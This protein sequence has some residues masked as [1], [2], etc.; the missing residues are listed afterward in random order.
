MSDKY[1]QS[2]E[3]LHENLYIR[4]HRELERYPPPLGRRFDD[5][6]NEEEE[7]KIYQYAHFRPV[8]PWPD[9]TLELVI[10]EASKKERRKE[11]SLI[12]KVV[13]SKTERV[14]ID[15]RN[16]GNA[17]AWF[18][19]DIA[20]IWEAFLHSRLQIIPKVVLWGSKLKEREHDWEAMRLLWDFVEGWLA[21]QGVKQVYTHDRDPAF[22]ECD[23]S[24]SPCGG[25][26]CEEGRRYRQFLLDREY[27][28]IPSRTKH[29]YKTLLKN[30]FFGVG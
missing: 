3:K 6:M 22:C 28:F 26:K 24:V 17:Q 8:V 27:R 9:V 20:V 12:G 7:Q 29:A 4:V 30:A 10:E 15:W 1:W 2:L 19:E 23:F 14:G 5:M 11:P 21:K 16:V 18:G 25:E 13:S